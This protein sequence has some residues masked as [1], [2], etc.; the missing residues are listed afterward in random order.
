M[1]KAFFVMITMLLSCVT[2]FCCISCVED[3]NPSEMSDGVNSN[4]DPYNSIAMDYWLKNAVDEEDTVVYEDINNVEVDL[5]FGIVS[6]TQ[7]FANQS[8]KYYK[9]PYSLVIYDENQTEITLRQF[10]D[11][12][13][14]NY[15]CSVKY[16]YGIEELVEKY[17]HSEKIIIPKEL[18]NKES[19]KISIRLTS[20]LEIKGTQTVATIISASIYYKMVDEGVEL[21]RQDFNKKVSEGVVEVITPIKKEEIKL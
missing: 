1:K 4:V 12:F 14:E 15:G 21:S 6:Y 3:A 17:S 9:P 8:K 7:S 13:T 2:I 20:M 11:F 19:G 16:A 10:D 5:F 18:F